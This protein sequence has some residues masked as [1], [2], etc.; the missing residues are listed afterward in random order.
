MRKITFTLGVA[1]LSL[2]LVACQTSV[3]SLSKG[4]TGNISY[5]GKEGFTLSGKLEL[6]DSVNGMA[7]AVILVHGAGG[8]GYRQWTWGPFLREQGLATMTIDYFGPRGH[9]FGSRERV[10]APIFDIIDA[11]NI[12]ATHPKID[13]ER[14]GVIGWSNGGVMSINAANVGAGLGGGRTLKAHVALYPVCQ[15]TSLGAGGSGSPVLILL[16]SND[17]FTTSKLCQNVVDVGIEGGR[18]VRM[19]VY[20]GAYHGW[21]GDYSGSFPYKNFGSVTFQPN[22]EVTTR[23]RRDV[24]DFLGRTLNV[25]S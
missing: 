22:G 24:M 10:P 15:Q 8:L 19:I 25:G 11:M 7:P 18:D 2:A 5:P 16:G 14:I 20:E 23:S 17:S 1:A 3:T 12:L 6:P 21:D 13:P 4:Q 9:S